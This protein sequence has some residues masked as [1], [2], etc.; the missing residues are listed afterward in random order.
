MLDIVVTDNLG[1]V[2]DN[3]K[4]FRNSIR[5]NIDSD[6]YCPVSKDQDPYYFRNDWTVL[7]FRAFKYLKGNNSNE[8]N[9]ICI[10]GTGSGLDAIGAI[11]IFSP[12]TILITDFPEEIVVKARD[13][14]QSNM[15]PDQE[16]E[17][18][19]IGSLF[20][21]DPIF[22]G[23]KYD[24]IYENL[25]NLPEESKTFSDQPI[26]ASFIPQYKKFV[27]DVP[28]K[29]VTALLSSHYILLKQAKKHLSDDGAVISSIGGRINF[30]LIK[31]MFDELGYEYD[32]VVYDIKKQNEADTNLPAY[33]QW[34]ENSKTNFAF[35]LYDNIIRQLEES[36]IGYDKYSG[37]KNNMKEVKEILEKHKLSAPQALKEFRN[38]KSIAHEVYLFLLKNKK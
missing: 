28:E 11:E 34:A 18:S 16:I 31:Q 4:F 24:L 12:Q 10:V 6:T 35:Y 25:P 30:E 3:F 33:S 7:A 5:L 13:N 37:Y 22:N 32:I 29:Y 2:I 23:A 1:Y 14:I 38:K 8:F 9:N 15:L 17:I 20:L 21:N 19:L 36:K 27:K 26:N